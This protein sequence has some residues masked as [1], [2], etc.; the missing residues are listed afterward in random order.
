ML[1]AI[2]SELRKLYTV[3]STYVVVALAVVMVIIFA[4]YGE[5]L[6]VNPEALH[7]PHLLASE[8]AEAI[9][10]VGILG[11]LVGV[12][13]V[14]HEYRYNTI[15]YTLTASRSRTRVLLAKLIAV[16]CFAVLFT[17]FI[18]ALSPA[19][20]A[21]GIHIKGAA[22]TAQS[23][24]FADMIWRVLLAGWGFAVL[25]F[26]V[27]VIIR[28]QVGAVAAMFLI[29]ATVEPLLGL[30]LKHN[31]VYLPFGNLGTILQSILGHTDISIQRAVAVLAAY[32]VAGLLAAWILFVRRDAS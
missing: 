16:S 4:F 7:N 2:K 1:A 29:P 27:A 15:V 23:F 11:A 3:R 28:M 18:G 20:T 26:I 22:L 32:V 25:T 17:L 14:T 5:G 19:M 8:T 21:L 30:L 10:A 31:A 24:P 12:L 6:R 9:Q 13:L